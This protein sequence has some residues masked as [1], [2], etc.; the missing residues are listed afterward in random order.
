MGR[1]GNST[2]H[3]V[4]LRGNSRQRGLQH[5]RQL[6]EPIQAAVDF[7]RCFFREH[8][9]MST[10]GMARRA[11]AFVGP[12]AELNP[13]LMEEYEGIAEGSGQRLEDVL[14]LT[15]RYEITFEQVALGD[16]SNLFVGPGRS[17]NGNTLLGQ[18]WD[19]R[20]EVLDFRAVLISR[21]DDQPDHVMVTECGQPGKYGFN[22]EGLGVVSAG[23]RCREKAATGRQLFTVLGRT[24]LA[25]T[26]FDAA[27]QVLEENAPL[28]TVNVLVADEEGRGADFEAT[29]GG[30]RR[31]D[32]GSDEVYWHTNHCRHV[33][34]PNHFENSRVRGLRWERLTAAQGP[35]ESETVR[36]WLADRNDGENSISQ[37]AD[38]DKA[39]TASWLQTLCSIAMDLNQR[40]LWVSDGPASKSSFRKIGLDRE[41]M[42]PGGGQRLS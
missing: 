14:A 9:G 13:L 39:H 3:V 11:S 19:W 6:K 2:L 15:A 22:Q 24:I 40:Q 34:E 28:A 32:L 26:N 29:P 17:R 4:E 31:H 33:V 7:Y 18:S 20:P 38:P 27:C 35:V 8:L 23:L 42:V 10:E 16:C 36:N 12:T 5:G 1:A 25:Q 30:I 21:C 41:R 37:H